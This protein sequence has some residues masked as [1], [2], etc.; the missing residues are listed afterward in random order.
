MSSHPTFHPALFKFL[1][2]IREENSRK[3]FSSIRP[4]YDDIRDNLNEFINAVIGELSKKDMTLSDIQAKQCLFRI[5]RDA[6]RLKDWDPIY[7]HNRGAHITDTGKKSTKAWYYIHLQSGWSF[8]WGW[9]YRPTSEQLLKIRN[10][11]TLHGDEYYDITSN[12][13]FKSRF[14]DIQ[15]ESLTKLPRWF[16]K[17]TP[18]PELIM[19]KQYLIYHHYTDEEILSQEFFDIIIKDCMVAKPFFDFL[20]KPLL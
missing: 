3:Y 19:K 1:D 13:K 2:A 4:L 17:E 14:W 11:L 15:W 6:R 12:K 10:F 16:V 7:K 9:I 20:N 18:Y 5:Y 8:L